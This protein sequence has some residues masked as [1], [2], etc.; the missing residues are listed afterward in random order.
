MLI[1]LFVIISLNQHKSLQQVPFGYVPAVKDWLK[2][3]GTVNKP[4]PELAARPVTGLNCDKLEQSGKRFWSLL[5]EISNDSPEK[6]FKNCFVHNLCPLAFFHS[7]G[8]NI[9]PAELKVNYL[10]VRKLIRILHAS[11]HSLTE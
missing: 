5:Q 2:L 9:T 7:S 10:K 1:R 11:V 8:K 3:T 6:F 4:S